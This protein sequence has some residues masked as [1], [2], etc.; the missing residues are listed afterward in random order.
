MVRGG[1]PRG[2]N[3]KHGKSDGGES[4]RGRARR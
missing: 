3:E 1:S 4:E 2:A